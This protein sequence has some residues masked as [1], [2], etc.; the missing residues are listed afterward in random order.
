[1]TLYAHPEM[2]RQ[3]LT[4][5]P[6][7]AGDLV[8]GAALPGHA[9][10]GAAH[11]GLRFVA[12]LRDGLAWEVRRDCVYTHATQ[13]LTRGTLVDSSSGAAV[14][15]GAG[16]VLRV[17]PTGYEADRLLPADLDG[18]GN[19]L[20]LVDRNG[21]QYALLPLDAVG[22]AVVNMGHRQNTLANLLALDG[23][24]GEIS[25]ATDAD[26]LVVH[27]GVAGEAVDF[28]RDGARMDWVMGHSTGSTNS[29]VSG[30]VVTMTF[31]AWSGVGN[32]D[33]LDTSTETIKIPDGA[34]VASVLL[35]GKIYPYPSGTIPA[36]GDKWELALELETGVGTGTYTEQTDYGGWAHIVPIASEAANTFWFNWSLAMNGLG[37]KAGR[38]FRIAM[39]N[40]GAQG[41]RIYKPRILVEFQR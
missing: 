14:A 23:V 11:D 30:A 40:T 33:L 6:G 25:V 2:I 16:T 5:A 36:V 32:A 4:A 12:S 27:N 21:N 41:Y 3:A 29:G 18:G 17:G 19:A 34:E 8:L 13:T 22:Q 15:L 35:M 39:K 24:P 26:A 38:R 20:R 1:M 31:S 7:V 9:A 28:R 37:S 10:L